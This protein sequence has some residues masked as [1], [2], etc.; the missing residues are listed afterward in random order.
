MV[1][2]YLADDVDRRIV[3]FCGNMTFIVLDGWDVVGTTEGGTHGRWWRQVWGCLPREFEIGGLNDVPHY[4]VSDGVVYASSPD[5]S[6]NALT[7]PINL[8][9]ELRKS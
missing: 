9:R 3:G 8:M 7:A 2:N 6:I 4:T 5:N 1:A